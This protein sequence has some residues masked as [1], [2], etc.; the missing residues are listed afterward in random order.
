MNGYVRIKKTAKLYNTYYRSR[1]DPHLSH[2]QLLPIKWWE[3]RHRN[4][5]WLSNA[6]FCI[7]PQMTYIE[8]LTWN[9]YV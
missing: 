7:L 4:L 8:V 3:H 1:K 5:P 2:S 6:R 9:V